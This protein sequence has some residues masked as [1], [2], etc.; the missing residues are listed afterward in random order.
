MIQ[1][2]K[3]YLDIPLLLIV[4][5]LSGLGIVFSYS[6][7]LQVEDAQNIY[8][9]ATVKQI[10]FFISGLTLMW[11]TSIINYKKIAE[12]SH[13]IYIGCIL[14]LI[15]TLV[16][17]KVVNNSK[18]WIDIGLFSIQ[19]SDVYQSSYGGGGRYLFG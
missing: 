2:K 6:S 3:S 9:Y 12:Y 7:N 19:P 5:A 17:G 18:R 11:I 8:Q 16:F 4:V 14:L 15:Y 1:P 13:F 10:F